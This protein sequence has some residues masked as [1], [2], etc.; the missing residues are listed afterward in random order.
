V[1]EVCSLELPPGELLL[2]DDDECS[3][4]AAGA[5]SAG[6][7]TTGAGATTTGAG[8]IATAGAG[9]AVVVELDEV[10]SVVC[11]NP[12]PTLPN[13]AAMPRAR[14]AVLSECFTMMSPFVLPM[15]GSNSE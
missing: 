6:T 14:A 3:V 1:L 7:T 8:Y 2:V 10:V 13:S 9:A 12:T 15:L 5:T 4:V 11:A